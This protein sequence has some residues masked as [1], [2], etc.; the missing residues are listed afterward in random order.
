MRKSVL[1]LVGIFPRKISFALDGSLPGEVS[2][3]PS[4]YFP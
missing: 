2:F 3:V 1:F 4:G